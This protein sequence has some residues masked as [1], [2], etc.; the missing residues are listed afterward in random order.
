[1]TYALRKLAFLLT[2]LFL[3]ITTTF[4]LMKSIP[5]DPFS[6][7]QGL[8]KEIYLSLKEHYGL[9]HPL[10]FQY[11]QYLLSVI[12]LDF[13]P[14]Y[15]YS[16]RSVTD[17]IFDCFPLSFLLGIMAF[18][19]SLLFGYT[20]G[21]FAAYHYKSVYDRFLTLFAVLGLSIPGFIL[22]TLLQYLFAIKWGILPVASWGS[23][24]HLI[25]PV[26]SLSVMPTFFIA[27]LVRGSMIEVLDKEYIKTALAKGVKPFGVVM[28]HAL[29]NASLPVIPY[30]G[31]LLTNL[32]VG[33]FV[34]EKIFSIPG[35][36]AWY[37]MSILERDY[38]VILGVTTFY[39][40]LLLTMMF[41]VDLIYGYLDPRIRLEE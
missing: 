4:I 3:L 30:L 36:G 14:S 5:G 26:I 39:G 16:G 28:K 6:E 20:L 29:K 10:F 15:K 11:T 35:L 1:M 24:S 7:E 2:T 13:G 22:S 18:S 32:I 31:T 19:T 41:I 9:H 8:P 37:I 21:L 23:F 33:S 34:I 40:I 17:I 25:I 12:K 27:K 38:T